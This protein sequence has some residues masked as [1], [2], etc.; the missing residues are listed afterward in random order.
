M[1]GDKTE[2]QIAE[3]HLAFE[4]HSADAALD[5][6]VHGALNGLQIL[7]TRP[8]AAREEHKR[9]ALFFGEVADRL[10]LDGE[11]ARRAVLSLGFA[12]DSKDA[13]ILPLRDGQEVLLQLPPRNASLSLAQLARQLHEDAGDLFLML[14][15][16]R[17]Y[18]P[19]N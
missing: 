11:Q 6:V 1:K 9:Y 14:A 4:A 7:R 10:H 16:L 5:A 12:I 19:A 17:P 8:Q 15:G 13:L 18:R 2:A 3:L